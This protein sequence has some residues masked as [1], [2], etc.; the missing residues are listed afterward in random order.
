MTMVSSV[1]QSQNAYCIVVDD[2]SS[3]DFL[4]KIQ[5]LADCFPNIFVLVNF[6]GLL[7]NGRSLLQMGGAYRNTR[8]GDLKMGG[9]YIS[10]SLLILKLTDRREL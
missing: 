1:Y 5:M 8:N 3:D 6:I 4:K 9:D 10:L 7:K 2:K